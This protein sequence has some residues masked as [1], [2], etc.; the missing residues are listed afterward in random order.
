MLEMCGTWRQAGPWHSQRVDA[1]LSETCTHVVAFCPRSRPRLAA[2]VP[3][4]ANSW[5]LLLLNCQGDR[6]QAESDGLVLT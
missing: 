4:L 5:Q 6:R 2:F 1:Q 3:E